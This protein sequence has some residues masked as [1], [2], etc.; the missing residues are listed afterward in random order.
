MTVTPGG[1]ETGSAVRGD[2][3]AD[4]GMLLRLLRPIFRTHWLRLAAVLSPS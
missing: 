3:E 2:R 4:I 1:I